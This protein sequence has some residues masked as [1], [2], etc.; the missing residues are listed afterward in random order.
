MGNSEYKELKIFPER[1]KILGRKVD[2]TFQDGE[3]MVGSA[4]DYEPRRSLFVLYS[5][6]P[7][8]NILR[9]FVLP[10]EVAKA[11]YAIQNLLRYRD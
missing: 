5:S 9:V 8:S 3:V 2:V 11:R 10:Q 7:H 6:D 4:L 1:V